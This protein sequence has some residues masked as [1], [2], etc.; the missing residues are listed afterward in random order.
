MTDRVRGVEVMWSQPLESRYRMG[1]CM[2]SSE[3]WKDKWRMIELRWDI[4]IQ[5]CLKGSPD[6]RGNTRLSAGKCKAAIESVALDVWAFRDWLIHD[7]SSGLDSAVVDAFLNDAA[8]YHIRACSD[9]ATRSKHF[10]VGDAKKHLLELHRVDAVKD[11]LPIVFR[12]K[13]V[14]QHPAQTRGAVRAPTGNTDEYEDAVEMVH[15]AIKQWR[16]FL[17]DRKLLP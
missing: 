17:T 6:E 7:T 5:E 4:C 12:A 15:R 1:L 16:V 8:G 2:T 13:R 11:N 3:T 14:F 9:L 10:A